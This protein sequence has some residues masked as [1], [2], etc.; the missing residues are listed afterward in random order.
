MEGQPG[1]E[2]VWTKDWAAGQV[3]VDI[4][5]VSLAEVWTDPS[6]H[7]KHENTGKTKVGFWTR[8]AERVR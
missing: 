7:L 2:A 4:D 5:R 3:K 1:R 6:G 8:Q